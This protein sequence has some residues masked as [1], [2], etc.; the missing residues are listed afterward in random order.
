MNILSIECTHAHL[1]VALLTDNGAVTEVFS[2]EWKKAAESLVPLIDQVMAEAGLDRHEL[3]AIAISSGPG[4]FTSL[5]IGMSVAK[6]VAYGLGLPLIPVPTMPAMAASL[7]DKADK[8]MAVI[9]SRKGEYY[10]AIY[11]QDELASGLWHDE[12]ARGSAADVLAA[13]SG[14]AG[15]VVVG[16][17]LAEIIPLLAGSGAVYREAEFF[18]AK[19]LI[20]HALRLFAEADAAELNGITPDYRQMF[21]PNGR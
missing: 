4:S 20:P 15:L 2:T 7:P 8:I 3:Q 19:S 1:S 17:G 9:P 5:R 14:H 13:A 6:G 11:N 18:T 12:I 16:R 10:F 21:T